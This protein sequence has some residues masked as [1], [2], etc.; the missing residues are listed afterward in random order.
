M[1]KALKFFGIIIGGLIAISIIL[2]LLANLM[3]NSW[4]DDSAL[5]GGRGAKF[6]GTNSYSSETLNNRTALPTGLT[7]QDSMM[8]VNEVVSSQPASDK[9][10][11][12]NGYLTLKVENVDNANEKIANIAAQNGG[13][14]FST[15]VSQKVSNIR[16]G[17]V[18]LKVPVKNFD[19]TF[20]EVKKVA[21]FV[22]SESISGQDV[23]EEYTDLQSQ[24][25]NK[26]EE[27]QAFSKILS[28]NTGKIEDILAVTKELARVRGEIEM[29]Q[30]RI[31]YMN[32][33]TEMSTITAIISEDISVVS[34]TGWRPWQVAK[35]E[36]NNMFKDLQKVANG[37]IVIVVRIIPI[38]IVLIAFSGIFYW[39]LRKIYQ[40]FFRQNKDGV[41]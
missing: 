27:E 15:N 7:K 35:I 29:I 30:G 12:K 18:T 24:L 40:K 22:S 26:Q 14:V 8:S 23:T 3:K 41:I 5:N 11:I 10:I 13:E 17:T 36:F 19:K 4:Y 34:A 33:Q 32:S 21:S 39:I 38:L 25:K 37:V 6:M 9:K 20:A 28:Q 2:I 1:K 16:S 31:K